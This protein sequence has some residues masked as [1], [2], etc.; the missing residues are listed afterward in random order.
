MFELEF[1][2]SLRSGLLVLLLGSPLALV[3]A[4]VAILFVC[5]LMKPAR[6]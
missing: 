6:F 2:E 5:R 1:V 3:G 4:A